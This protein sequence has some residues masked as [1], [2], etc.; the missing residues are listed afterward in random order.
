M[1]PNVRF[2]DFVF[3]LLAWKYIFAFLSDESVYG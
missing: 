1:V 2:F 3:S